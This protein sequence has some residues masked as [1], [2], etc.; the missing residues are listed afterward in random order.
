M[1]IEK[2][3]INRE[4]SWLSFNER[5]LQEAAD[6]NVP[7]VERFRFLGIFSNNQDEFFKVRV[8][9]IKR[10]IDVEK[11]TGVKN[12]E[13][14]KKVLNQ[15]QQKVIDLQEKFEK[16]YEDL[17]KQLARQ[18][19]YIINESQLNFEQAAYVRQF[20]HEKVLSVINPIMLHNLNHFPAIKDKSIYLAIKMISILN[21]TKP[22][23]AIIEIPSESVSRFVVLPSIQRKR[24]IILLDDVI[25]YCLDDVFSTFHFD[26]YEA[27]TIK[28]TRD[29]ELDIDNDLSKSLLEKISESVSDRKKGQPVRFVYDSNTPPDLLNYLKTSLD[30]DEDDNLIPGGRYHNF[31][32]YMQFPNLGGKRMVY[33]STPPVPHPILKPHESKIA[34]IR[35]KDLLIHVPYQKFDHYINLL[36]EAAIDP[37]VNSIKITLYRVAADSRVINTLSNAAMNGKKVTV[38]I[39]LQA[40][41]DEKANI[42]W[43]KRLEEAG[44]RVMFGMSGLKVHSK[45][46]LIT[47]TD[48]KQRIDIAT[49]GTGNF[50]ESTAR[51]YSDIHLFTADPRITDEVY[52]IFKF[53]EAS[54]KTFK[55]KY[56]PVSPFNMRNRMNS[57]I[58]NEIRNAREGKEA[59]VLIKLNSLV[60]T[61]MV[62]KLY[63]ANIAGVKIKAIIRGICSLI[64]GVPGM[65][66][67]IEV[68][69]IVDKFLEHSR[70]F[71]F[72]NGGNELYY[73]SSA[74]W[75]PRNLDHRIEVACPIYS[76]DNQREIKKIFEIQFR[77]NVKSRII[78]QQQDNPYKVTNSHRKLQSQVELYKL[79]MNYSKTGKLS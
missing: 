36:R 33:K 9:T 43:S 45:L 56:L 19:I 21:E 66:E 23:Y 25:R 40:R 7:L 57:L 13:K 69:S 2:K 20:F 18:K 62:K 37:R 51:V 41:F 65:S 55:Y 58:D 60:D 75:M 24:Y 71:I 26:R 50:N 63:Q 77:D 6:P 12:K 67:N 61:D 17:I 78:N 72:C 44:A 32:D 53:F 35:K 48:D 74:D 64:P 5:V 28:L 49:I 59:Y 22:E 54:Y 46:T 15:I 14:P 3:I 52:K 79:Y 16:V 27:Y 38:I 29:A 73:L 4:I 34:E 8:A 70:L 1:S 47:L 31:K 11:S 68:I 42:Y 10:M 76:K 30:L 39:E